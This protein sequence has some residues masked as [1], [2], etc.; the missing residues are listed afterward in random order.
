ML[1]VVWVQVQAKIT[2]VK[3]GPEAIEELVP[4]VS[5]Y[6]NTQNRVNE[7]DFSA[8]HPFHVKIEQLS[9]TIF[10]PGERQRWFYERARGQYEVARSRVGTT[11]SRLRTFDET[12]PRKQKDT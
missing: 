12:T 9:E 5:R 11:A 8:N 3:G 2:V 7:A 6:A 10:T 4:L 1:K